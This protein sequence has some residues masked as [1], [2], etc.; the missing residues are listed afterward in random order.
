MATP[1]ANATY[2]VIASWSHNCDAGGTSEPQTLKIRYHSYAAS[3]PPPRIR[4]A[5]ILALRLDRFTNAHVVTSSSEPSTTSATD[6]DV[7]TLTRTPQRVKY[8]VLAVEAFNPA[9]TTVSGYAQVRQGTTT[10][11]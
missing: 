10:L 6:Q 2:W 5:R 7:L 8:A 3:D 9:S 4:D 1:Q 11:S